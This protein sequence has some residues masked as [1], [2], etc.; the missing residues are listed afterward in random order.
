MTAADLAIIRRVIRKAARESGGY[1]AAAAMIRGIRAIA[2]RHRYAD[3]FVEWFLV[4]AELGKL[5]AELQADRCVG[6]AQEHE[7]LTDALDESDGD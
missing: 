2:N 6:G 4:E 1:A 5:D 7:T 3:G